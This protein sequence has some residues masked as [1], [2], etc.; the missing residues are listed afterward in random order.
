MSEVAATRATE[1][2]RLID[3]F[4]R[5][6]DGDAW[7]G[8]PVMAVLERVTFETAGAKP[9]KA[10]HSIRDIVRHMTAWTHEVRRR[11]NGEPA[12][13]PPGGDWPGAAGDDKAAWRAEVAE[14]KAANDALVADLRAFDDARLLEPITDK[15]HANGRGVTRYVLLHGLVQH[16]AYHSGQIAILAKF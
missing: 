9:A 12:A 7:H 5:A 6:V 16:H 8:D 4:A 15:R 10:A 13:E 3:Q 14:F 1:V 11:L 2:A